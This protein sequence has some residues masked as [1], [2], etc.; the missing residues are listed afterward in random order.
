MYG[1]CLDVDISPAVRLMTCSHMGIAVFAGNVR[2]TDGDVLETYRGQHR[3]RRTSTHVRVYVGTRPLDAVMNDVASPSGRTAHEC[4]L[5]WIGRTTGR[6]GAGAQKRRWVGRGESGGV[7]AAHGLDAR[8]CNRCDRLG[9]IGSTLPLDCPGGRGDAYAH[10]GPSTCCT[11]ALLTPVA[12]M[13]VGV[14]MASCIVGPH[15]ALN[16]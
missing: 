7:T 3:V 9:T 6:I 10:R 13:C 14:R 15:K 11:T 2:V 4:S 8:C 5:A 1:A 16:V 12:Q